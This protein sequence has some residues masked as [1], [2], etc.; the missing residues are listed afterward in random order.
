ML[1]NNEQRRY[2]APTV[3]TTPLPTI[4][5]VQGL[6]SGC[7]LETEPPLPPLSLHL[8]PC[9]LDSLYDGERNKAI[10]HSPSVW[11]AC[12]PRHDRAPQPRRFAMST[13]DNKATV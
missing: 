6:D 3:G 9:C 10:V 2:C 12:V 11:H 4:S 8:L 1:T 7:M 5:V 13:K